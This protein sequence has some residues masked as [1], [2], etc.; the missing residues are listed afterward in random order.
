MKKKHIL[1]LSA[2]TVVIILL[3]VPSLLRYLAPS[4]T[5]FINDSRNTTLHYKIGQPNSLLADGVLEYPD[6]FTKT[7]Y[8]KGFEY[9][10]KT[11]DLIYSFTIV[12][13]YGDEPVCS[14]IYNSRNLENDPAQLFGIHIGNP[15]KVEEN[16]T[17]N[18]EARSIF[19]FLTENG[20]TENTDINYKESYIEYIDDVRCQWHCWQ[21]D[22]VQLNLLIEPT[23]AACL[24]AFE[25]ILISKTTN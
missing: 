16:K 10:S 8:E 21:K 18:I 4:V 19:D 11:S 14:Y 24:R 17:L 23:D 7:E 2:I 9:R 3:L 22:N 15:T 20:F 25:I 13:G 6:L 5:T 1:I 12:E